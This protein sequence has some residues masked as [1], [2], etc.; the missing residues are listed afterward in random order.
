MNLVRF[1]QNKAIFAQTGQVD[2]ITFV[3][4]A[5]K[6]VSSAAT[7]LAKAV[8]TILPAKNSNQRLK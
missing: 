1:A 5:P 6:I 7:K 8:P 2:E 3:N 4:I